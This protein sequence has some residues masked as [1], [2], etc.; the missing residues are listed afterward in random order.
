M[1]IS[2]LVMKAA[3]LDLNVELYSYINSYFNQAHKKQLK[4]ERMPGGIFNLINGGKHGTKNLE[5][6]EFRED[7][8][9]IQLQS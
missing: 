4:L 9:M 1:V 2:Q 6:Q 8:M 3:A 5:F 7:W